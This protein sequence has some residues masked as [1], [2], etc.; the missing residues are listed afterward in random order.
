MACDTESIFMNA[1]MPHVGDVMWSQFEGPEPATIVDPHSPTTEITDLVPGTYI[2]RWANF[3][4]PS[5]D[6]ICDYMYVTISASAFA[7][8]GPDTIICAGSD[9]NIT[10]AS[11]DNYT[12]LAWT[13][14]GTGLFSDPTILNPVYSPTAS[15]ILNGFAVLTLTAH[16]DPP[17]PPVSSAMYLTIK[18]PGIILAID[19]TGI[20]VN[21]YEGGVAVD[22]ILNNDL[23]NGLPVDPD[24]VNISII[25][26]A[27]A[28]G[29]ILNTTTGE[30][31]VDAGTPAGT[32][33]IVYEICESICPG[34]CSQ[35]TVT[36][37]VLAPDILA[38]DDDYTPFPV[39][40]YEGNPNVGNAL[41]NDLLNGEPVDIDEITM[42]VLDPATP[43]YPGT[44]VPVVDPA[45]GIVSVP[46]QTPAGIYSITYQICEDLN[47]WNCDTAVITVLVEAPDI[48][49]I[50]DDYTP[51]PVNGYEGNPNVGNALD[52]DLLNGEPFDIDEITM[53][54]LDPAT[55]IYPGT[56]VPEV[57]PETGIVSVPPQTPAGVYSITYQICENLNPWNCDE[58]VITVL[59]E[60]PV[61]IANDDFYGPVNG[62]VD[63][64]NAGNILIN[65]LLN[66]E[67]ADIGEVSISVLIPSTHP[68][69]A[70]DVITGIV[71][72]DAG[73]PEGVYTITYQIC[74]ILNP[75]NCDQATITVEV[76]DP[77][78]L[79]PDD[80]AICE[81]ELP[82]TLSGAY[83]EGGVYSGEFVSNNVFSGDDCG[84]YTISYTY[85]DEEGCT[86]SC[87]FMIT[88]YELP[89]PVIMGPEEVLACSEVDYIVEENSVCNDPAQITYEWTV[90]G[91]VFVPGGTTTE[92][93]ETVT[94]KWDHN[95]APGTLSV[96]A[97]VTDIITC[98][99]FYELGDIIKTRPLIEGQVKYWNQFETYMPT[100]YHTQDY[101]TYP[102]DYFYVELWNENDLLDTQ[103][104]EP[105]LEPDLIE[106]LS[107]FKFELDDHF[108]DYGCDG[109]YLKI[110]DGG[111]VYHYMQGGPNPPP[112]SG[113]NLGANFTYNN[114]GGVNAT[115]ALAIQY[116]ATGINIH[117]A[118]YNFIWVGSF[119]GN[120]VPAYGYYSHSAADV[121]SS[122]PY[123]IGGITAL[124]ALTTNYRVVG[125][126]D[127]FPN[128][129]PGI[130]YSP[131]YRVT[132]RMVDTLPEIT[133]P[134]P[135]NYVFDSDGNPV[136]NAAGNPDD[137][138]FFHSET[139]YLYFTEATAHKYTSEPI[140]LGNKHKIN[141]YYLALGDLNS[142]YEPTLT[143]AKAETV[144]TLAFEG[145][146]AVKKGD[147]ISIPVR[148]SHNVELGA[149][150][151]GLNYRT[152][153][154]EVLSVSQD[155]NMIDADKGLIRIAWADRNPLYLSNG[156][157]VLTIRA[158]ILDDLSPD[159]R[160]FEL[161]GLTELADGYAQVLENIELTTD[162]LTTATGNDH[163]FIMNYPNPF[164]QST[165]ISYYLPEA[166]RVNL[167]V[168][169]SIGQIVE[170]LISQ[171]QE[172]GTY[173]V[174]F[175]NPTI[176][177][178]A[179]QYRIILEG[180]KEDYIQ[181]GTM[182]HMP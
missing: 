13:T 26:P 80:F 15:D 180:E 57:D 122:K 86:K 153:L 67:P 5:C 166:G 9:Y 120:H 73:T 150:T 170:T 30:V 59:V 33:T 131:N 157:T 28:T 133:W 77:I 104:V 45:T 10:V 178:G 148:V 7:D 14:S 1:I 8:A 137:V 44:N 156:E 175:N 110:W 109:Y 70:L 68:G 50:D 134:K 87:S 176:R 140:S 136:M 141:I 144:Q 27:E 64:P 54:V 85:T 168:Y 90:T 34:D 3:N 88:V 31:T 102:H 78:V 181:S 17:C 11:A 24:D 40:G 37:V 105:R 163:L 52:N 60:A 38:I 65:D 43:I 63:N 174:E 146:R 112:V 82:Y 79:C 23:L 116:M 36:V 172:T 94:V 155:E 118:P 20:P 169:N 71:S 152:D 149:I 117:A 53:T 62:C 55:P 39:N 51:N 139:S 25:V 167:V 61:I 74:E 89:V 101:A 98:T 66:D 114:W 147:I 164:R 135:F 143:P 182:I 126:L 165:F 6:T 2:F 81:D 173:L 111:L 160:Y 19:D 179:Y 41:D 130:Q 128:N 151:M 47:P 72:V 83:P 154:I 124:D 162:A 35:A 76:F 158:R 113:T 56:N 99:G 93:G 123:I 16:S 161:E 129:Q 103:I 108:D 48:L 75:D 115:D 138:P 95:T 42:T 22:N 159:T 32:Y 125:L 97:S 21:G 132:G 91:G 121:N 145:V 92:T 119:N 29:V 46:P 84:S 100:P 49:A 69:V 18:S 142:S 106:L 96:I 107:Y 12:S 127:V 177:P 58:A 4:G 171:H